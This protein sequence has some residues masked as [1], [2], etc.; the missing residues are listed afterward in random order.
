MSVTLDQLRVAAAL[1]HGALDGDLELSGA[2]RR[3]LVS[4]RRSHATID[5]C[6]FRQLVLATVRGCRVGLLPVERVR[7]I[8]GLRD[9]GGGVYESSGPAGAQRRIATFLGA[10][11]V[12]AT[13]RQSP[14][15][16]GSIVA[17]VGGDRELGVS[18]LTLSAA[19][20]G[21]D[22]LLDAVAQS[23]AAACMVEEL[24]APFAAQPR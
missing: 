2:G 9:I 10:G 22:L 17:H 13:L 14:D 12:E 1:A 21:V 8:G 18:V 23:F 6:G 16:G 4:F 7:F 19:R 15:S 20:P 5:P 3:W 11:A 24:I